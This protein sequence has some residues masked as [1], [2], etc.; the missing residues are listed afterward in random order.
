MDLDQKQSGN[1]TYFDRPRGECDRVAELMM[2]KFTESGHPV[3]RATS[4]LSRGALKSKGGGQLSIHFCAEGDTIET[5]LRT[6]ISVNQLSIDG[7]VSDLCEEYS[8]C[9]TRT[10]RPVLA[11]QSDPLLEPANLLITTPTRSIEVLAQENILHKCKERVERLPQQDCVIKICTDAEFL[12]TVEVGQNF[13][14]KDT[15]GLSQFTEP[16]DEFSQFTEPVTCR[17][18]TLPRNE[19]STDPKLGVGQIFSW[20]EQVGHRF[21]RQRVRRQRA[22]DL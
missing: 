12:T 16:T 17:E 6:F 1:S 3:F 8:A 19:K 10:V 7:A 14:T 5:V 20:T 9:Q 2:I 11:G 18:Y 15:D 4:P 21:D 13:M 22:G